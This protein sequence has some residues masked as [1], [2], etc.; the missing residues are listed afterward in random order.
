MRIPDGA[1]EMLYRLEKD[2]GVSLVAQFEDGF[3]MVASEDLQLTAFRQLTSDFESQI[4]GATAIASVLDIYDDEKSDA[5]LQKILSPA[6]FEIWPLVDTNTYV[7]DLSFQTAGL[8]TEVSNP[9]RKRKK[10]TTEEF[11][12]RKRGWEDEWRC[13]QIAW[14]EKQIE[15]EEQLNRFLRPYGGQI[16]DQVGEQPTVHGGVVKFPIA[17]VRESG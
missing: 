10:E 16:I 3:L 6:L 17:S 13:A 5:R 4:H 12:E 7:L 15:T 1:E 2:F 9:P 11:E 8:G 14:D